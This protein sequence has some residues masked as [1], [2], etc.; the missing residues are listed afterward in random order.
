MT[1]VPR[2][3]LVL[4]LVV[5]PIVV[6][7]TSLPL[8]ARVATHFGSGGYANGYMSHDGYVLFMLVMTTLLPISIVTMTGLVPRFAIRQISQRKRAY[9]LA[10][11]RRAATLAWLASHACALGVLITVFLLGIHLLTIEANERSP[12]RLDE[13]S[14]FV[15]LIGF[16]VL[17]AIW[18]LVLG[19]RF[20]RMR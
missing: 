7:Q 20:T 14:L 9:W 18:I 16:V 12:A 8:P 3:V 17:L 13:S 11:E 1:I 4:A 2:L 10:P 15:V 19:L 6:W 5:A